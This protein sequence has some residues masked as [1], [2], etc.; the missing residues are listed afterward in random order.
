M[1][2]FSAAEAEFL[3]DATFAFFWDEFGDFDSVDDHDIRVKNFR[4]RGVGEGVVRLVGGFGV[5]SSDVISSLPLGLESGG[6][7]VPF[8]DGGRNGVH[9]HD[10]AH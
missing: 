3:L 4:G 8:I 6:L 5:S 10:A 2:K 1:S 7:L 9:G